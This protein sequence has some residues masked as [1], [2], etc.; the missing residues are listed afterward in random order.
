MIKE[1]DTGKNTF[2]LVHTLHC[3][4]SCSENTTI[5]VLSLMIKQAITVTSIMPVIKTRN[6]LLVPLIRL[7]QHWKGTSISLCGFQATD[8]ALSDKTLP[9]SAH[10]LME[11][12]GTCKFTNNVALTSR[13]HSAHRNVSWRAAGQFPMLPTTGE[14]DLHTQRKHVFKSCRILPYELYFKVSF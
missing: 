2:F 5:S 10:N 3:P 11:Q 8:L 1:T 4:V 12:N 6:H 14:M 7:A 9:V 13:C